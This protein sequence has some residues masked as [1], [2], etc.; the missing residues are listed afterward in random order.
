[1]GTVRPAWSDRGAGRDAGRRRG[2]AAKS[3]TG[4]HSGTASAHDAEG[5]QRRAAAPNQPGE[6]GIAASHYLGLQLPGRRGL[7][8][9]AMRGQVPRRKSCRGHASPQER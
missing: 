4:I 3:R 2:Q 1:M 6:S 5:E 7:L 9:A 8:L